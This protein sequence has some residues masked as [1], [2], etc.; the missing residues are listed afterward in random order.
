MFMFLKCLR[1]NPLLPILGFHERKKW[2]R[3][4]LGEGV[5]WR[6]VALLASVLLF[7]WSLEKKRQANGSEIRNEAE[8]D[9][10]G[11]KKGNGMKRSTKQQG[12]GRQSWKK[13]DRCFVGPRWQTAAQ[14]KNGIVAKK[15]KCR[16]VCDRKGEKK[17]QNFCLRHTQTLDKTSKEQEGE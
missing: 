14:D 10:Q 16:V 9:M 1:G 7:R 4:K 11:Q 8:E 12:G 15:V 13:A 5:D 6:N 17:E 2:M 3:R